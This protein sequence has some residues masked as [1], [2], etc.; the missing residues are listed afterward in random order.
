MF[1]SQFPKLSSP[2]SLKQLQKSRKPKRKIP[3]LLKF[4][5]YVPYTFPYKKN[6]N[7]VFFSC[8]AARQYNGN[9]TV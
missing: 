2:E 7:H 3:T 1:H 8:I 9:S 5:L 6:N 4:T